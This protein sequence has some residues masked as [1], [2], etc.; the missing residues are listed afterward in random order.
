[1]ENNLSPKMLDALD[2]LRAH[3]PTA[4]TVERVAMSTWKALVRRD[5][6]ELY[7]DADRTYIRNLRLTA[8]GI[9]ATNA[10]R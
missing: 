10:P 5:L 2:L 9:E 4:Y 3:G 6:V 8:A 7:M 1:M